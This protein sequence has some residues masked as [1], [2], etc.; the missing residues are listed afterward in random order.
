MK[1]GLNQNG[2]PL[3]TYDE[4]GTN[5]QKFCFEKLLNVQKGENIIPDGSYI[6]NSKVG[7]DSVLEIPNLSLK[8]ESNIQIG[9]KNKKANQIFNFKY[10]SEDGTYTIQMQHSGKYIDTKYG[11]GKNGTKVQQ[12]DQNETNAQKWIIIKNSDDTY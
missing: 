7:N 4:N 12:Y 5:A 9:K 1:W 6:I 8:N 10:N 2:Q 3:Q 11:V